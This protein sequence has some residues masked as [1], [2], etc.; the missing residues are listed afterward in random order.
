M[1]D[2]DRIIGLVGEQCDK[3]VI[4]SL[5]DNVVHILDPSGKKIKVERFERG[6]DEFKSLVFDTIYE[7]MRYAILVNG[8]FIFNGTMVDKT[9]DY[10]YKTEEMRKLRERWAKM[11][12]ING[13]QTYGLDEFKIHILKGGH[14]DMQLYFVVHE[15]AYDP[16]G[17]K[18]ETLTSDEIF[19]KYGIR[20]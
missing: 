7:N 1:V 14:T 11:T 3:I 12:F 4:E 10:V 6:S 2:M 16:I 18:T 8:M 9:M 5:H 17:H 15:S 13:Y 20:V 19:T